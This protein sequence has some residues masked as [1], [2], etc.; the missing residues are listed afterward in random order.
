MTEQERA[1]EADG[2]M[3]RYRSGEIYSAGS[4]KVTAISTKL[5]LSV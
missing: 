4:F 5:P 1:D 3:N 2:E